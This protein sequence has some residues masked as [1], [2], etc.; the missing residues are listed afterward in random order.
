MTLTTTR[1]NMSFVDS[2]SRQGASRI[3]DVLRR[4]RPGL[5]MR[6]RWLADTSLR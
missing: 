2:I 5:R 6:G 1:S 3:P 4:R